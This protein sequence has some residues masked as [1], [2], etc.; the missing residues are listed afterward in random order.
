MDDLQALRA[1]ISDLQRQIARL[2]AAIERDEPA[3]APTAVQSVIEFLSA[4]APIFNGVGA[5]AWSAFDASQVIGK[6]AR[7][8][9]LE[10]QAA[11]AAAAAA[12]SVEV[13]RFSGA[14]EYVACYAGAA[15]P[16]ASAVQVIVPVARVAGL[17]GFEYRVVTGFDVMCKINLIGWIR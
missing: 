9:V 11:T 14:V 3:A 4:K 2:D 6:E 8:A 1:R 17:V 12:A 5:V 7:F 13:R 15:Q 16:N 10:I